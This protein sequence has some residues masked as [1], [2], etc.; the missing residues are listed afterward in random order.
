TTGA[1]AR[2]TRPGFFWPGGGP[3][4]GGRGGGAAAADS[5]DLRR[6][7]EA[8]MRVFTEAARRQGDLEAGAARIVRRGL[9]LVDDSFRCSKAVAEN[10]LELLVAPA[11]SDALEHMLQLGLLSAYIPEF[12]AIGC[13]VQHDGYHVHTADVHS[14]AT[15][16]ELLLLREGRYADAEPVLTDLAREQADFGLLALAALLHDV[17]KGCSEEPHNFR[18]GRLVEAIAGRLGVLSAQNTRT[19]KRLVELHLLLSE[20]AERHDL[21]DEDTLGRLAAK[22]KKNPDFL[23]MLYILTFIDSKATGPFSWTTWKSALMRELYFKLQAVLEHAEA[24]GVSPPAAEADDMARRLESE[25][26]PERVAWH[27]EQLP[28]GY[29]GAVDADTAC[30]HILLAE[31]FSRGGPKVAWSVKTEGRLS[32][33]SLCAYDRPGLLAKAAGLFALH[34]L[35]IHEARVFTRRDNI[36]VDSFRLSPVLPGMGT[37]D[38]A[39]VMAD[40]TAGLTGKMSLP[41]R[42]ARKIRPSVLERNDLPA[43]RTEVKISNQLSSL[44]TVIEVKT[45][46]RVGLLYLLAEALFELELNILLA[47]VTTRG[48][49]ARDVF[50]VRDFSGNKI[51][52]AKHMEEIERALVFA[53]DG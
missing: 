44:N 27:M 7:P 52:D 19:L 41:Y 50:F 39:K 49:E 4:P 36:V 53:L 25:L 8:L 20:V 14:V 40:M 13:L 31:E 34:G 6:R 12:E 24:G 5:A 10:F 48:H 46:D 18:G 2:P 33:L 1:P 3:P 15:V 47:R 23:K 37:P 16:G 45:R 17:G 30:R 51:Y 43:V 9:A 26:A 38:W 11:A 21:G 32:T 29:L 42:L 28:T 35:S 22:L